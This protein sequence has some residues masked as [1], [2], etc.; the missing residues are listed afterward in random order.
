VAG[1]DAIAKFDPVK[2]SARFGEILRETAAA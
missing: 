1:V 2:L